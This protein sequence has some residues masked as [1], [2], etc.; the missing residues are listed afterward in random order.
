KGGGGTK[1]KGG[2]G[3]KSKGQAGTE[4]AASSDDPSKK[5]QVDRTRNKTSDSQQPDRRPTA[6]TN[7]ALYVD[8]RQAEIWTS[9]GR[10]SPTIVKVHAFRPRYFVNGEIERPCW[11]KTD[12]VTGQ[13]LYKSAGHNEQE[14]EVREN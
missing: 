5:V 13:R 1:S 8:E 2:G 6:R 4:P 14:S 12:E 11:L 9:E 7:D 3:T 10:T